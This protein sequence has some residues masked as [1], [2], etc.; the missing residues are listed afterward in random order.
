[1][2]MSDY[3]APSLECNKVSDSMLLQVGLAW[4]ECCAQLKGSIQMQYA[5]K[6]ATS[7]CI[8]VIVECSHHFMETDKT[9]LKTDIS[10][11]P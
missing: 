7:G 9:E 3:L 10:R 4:S 2:S 11:V 6:S 8:T 1:M 5:K